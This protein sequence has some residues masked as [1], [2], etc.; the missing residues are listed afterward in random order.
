MQ[1][2]LPDFADAPVRVATLRVATLRVWQSLCDINLM[3]MLE[4]VGSS[5]AAK[6]IVVLLAFAETLLQHFLNICL[7]HGMPLKGMM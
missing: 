4:Q 3:Q 5:D 6:S 2:A 7:I 1:R